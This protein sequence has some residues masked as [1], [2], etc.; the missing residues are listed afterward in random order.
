MGGLA[1]KK[2]HNGV[3]GIKE[4]DKKDIDMLYEDAR[5]FWTDSGLES[6]T[7]TFRNALP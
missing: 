3:S 5:L 2:L 4:M 1:W 6:Y 7:S